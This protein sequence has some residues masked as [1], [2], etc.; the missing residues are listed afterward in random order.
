MRHSYY[1]NGRQR[2]EDDTIKWNENAWDERDEQGILIY[3][4]SQ[5]SYKE[6]DTLPGFMLISFVNGE[7]K[8]FASENCLLDLSNYY[9]RLQ[10]LGYETS[11]GN[12]IRERMEQNGKPFKYCFVCCSQ[13]FIQYTSNQKT[14][15]ELK[16]L[17]EKQNPVFKQ[18]VRRA[19]ERKFKNHRIIEL[20]DF[21]TPDELTADEI[22][23]QKQIE[24]KVSRMLGTGYLEV[25]IPKLN[26]KDKFCSST[27]QDALKELLFSLC[28]PEKRPA[29]RHIKLLRDEN[30]GCFKLSE[31]HCLINGDG[32][33][34]QRL[35]NEAFIQKKAL[36]FP[37][38][39]G[40]FKLTFPNHKVFI[41]Y[42]QNLRRRLTEILKGIYTPTDAAHRRTWW[43]EAFT[44][45]KNAAH[46]VIEFWECENYKFAARTA[47][48]QLTEEEKIF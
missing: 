5:V 9:N 29:P 34:E 2:T 18:Q 48:S 12:L 8:C 43:D 14:A 42:S 27:P 38:T 25:S 39:C 21:E 46:T 45:D 20:K 30:G 15:A 16:E 10:S 4:V 7:S 17:W 40:Y 37:E 6:V 41:S 35:E 1:I 33:F 11:I 3:N 26:F 31:I 19:A 13:I 28:T 24:E 22:V 36:T 44:W 32:E 23:L 47:I